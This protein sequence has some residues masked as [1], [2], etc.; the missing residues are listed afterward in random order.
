MTDQ[1][2]GSQEGLLD[3]HQTLV[4]HL[5]DLRTRVIYSGY[6][7]MLATVIC[8]GF[9]EKIFAFIRKPIAPYLPNGGLVFTGPMDK[10]L[11]HLKLSFTCGVI[12][13]CPFWLYQI[14]LFVAPGLYSREKKYSLSFIFSGSVLFLCGT[15]FA[16]FIVMPMAFQF[17]MNFG[18]DIDKPMITIDHY[19]SFFLQMCLMFG[20]AFEMPL[21]LVLLGMMGIVSQ[22]FLKEKRRYAVLGLAVLAAIIT[23]PDLLSMLMMLVPLLGLYEIA[24]FVVGLVEKKRA[25]AAPVNQRE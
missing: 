23:P 13:S 19:I 7:L 4:E 14:W 15:S 6:A 2:D 9:S 21:I 16:Y 17:L 11:A 22:K 18:G 24:V 8:Y 25:A 20:A 12:I 5:S 3:K 1:Q 10:F